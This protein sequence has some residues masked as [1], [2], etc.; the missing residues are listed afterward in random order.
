MRIQS[1][2]LALLL[3]ASMCAPMVR[4]QSPVPVS[5][6]IEQKA[7]AMLGK[8]TLE[9][10]IDLLGGVDDF[11]IREEPNAG[12][13]RLKM[14]DGPLGV[15]TWGPATAYAAG[16]GLAAAW[17]PALAEK[18]GVSLGHDARARGV[19]FLL[20]PGVNI[21]RAPMNGRNFEYFGEDPYLAART[22][23]GYIDGVQSQG[24]STTVKH[25]A[26]NDEEYDR[27]N[28]SSDVDERTMR[29]IYL[30]AFEAAVREAH[31]GAVMNSYN[32]L[33][34]VH[35][36]QNPFLNIQVLR[37]DWGFA[38]VLMSD[39]SS[40]YDAVGAANGGL[41]LEMGVGEF[42][43]RKNLLLAIQQ[44]KVTTTTIDEKV[45]RIFIT[46]LRFG[47]L[48]RPQTDLSLPLYSQ[49][50][51]ELALRGAR[52]SITLLKNEGA[53]LPLNAEKGK[54][55]AV[56]GPDAWPAVPGGGGSSTV[57]PFGAVSILEGIGNQ[58]PGKV[59]VLYAR[60]LP[61]FDEIVDGTKYDHDVKLETFGNETFTGPSTVSAAR[62]ISTWK[63]QSWNPSAPTKH[64][65]RYTAT[66]T[67]AKSGN[68]FFVIA[69]N[70]SDTYKLTIDGKQVLEQVRREG[71]APGFV[72]VPLEAEKPASIQLDYLNDSFSP[73]ISLGIRAVDDMVSP[74]AR[75][76]AA[77]ADTAV[78]AVGFD[79]ASE[80][81]GSDRTFSLPW[82]QDA[83]IQ[84]V[85]R[86]NKN[87]IVTITAGGAVDMRPWIDRVPAI[88]HNWYPGQEG[89]TALAEILFGARSPEGKLPASF[90]RSWDESPV[91]D[92]YYAK[93]GADG[94]LH[95][96]YSEG[97]FYGYRYY[98]SRNKKPLFPFGFGLSYT[99]FAFS[100]LEIAP[101]S[102]KAG[103]EV[104]VSFDVTNTGSRDGAE[105]AQLYVGDPSATVKRPVMELKGFEKVRLAPGEKKHVTLKLNDRSFSYFDE[106]SHGWKI[107]PGRFNI[108]V[109]DS[110]ENTPLKGELTLS[111]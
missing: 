82:G 75:K 21:Y 48:D 67:P 28:V 66:Y 59:T 36:T 26:A 103:D 35:A 104:A 86:L 37:K 27:H 98:T 55:I 16:I 109:G 46:A 58:A 101:R 41:D 60:G 108:L 25:Y 11:Y 54:T 106:T 95:V 83:L 88:L 19:N 40:T 97:L 62:S 70:G 39:W 34:G 32:L 29:E 43:N 111:R 74:E 6:A 87:T 110:S 9:Q 85:A 44:G 61:T 8:L 30:P 7:D 68:Y 90:D 80:Q 63:P 38:G 78:V 99:T 79:P 10:K 17:D 57:T 18:V 3:S 4:A 93:M 100:N 13:P 56:L 12:F 92:S 52:E 71:Q 22:A 15:R 102:A 49:E 31:T 105:V 33:N 24:V 2:L 1:S 65:I 96:K 77:L 91:H 45:R 94:K 89:G 14:S 73:Q 42:M 64:S 69:A 84:S 47:F 5:P 53:L 20:G 51:R 72:E 50:G 23:V 76:I 81:E 107:D